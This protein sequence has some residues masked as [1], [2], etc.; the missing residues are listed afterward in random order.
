M[1]QARGRR[2]PADRHCADAGCL[3][4]RFEDDSTS[5]RLL[6][7]YCLERPTGPGLRTVAAIN[8]VR[9]QRLR[10]AQR[11]GTLPT[12]FVPAGLLSL[13]HSNATSWST[14]NPEF[15][16]SKPLTRKERRR[17]VVEAVRRIA[18]SS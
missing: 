7:W 14:M 1:L 16:S 5:L 6:T 13:I 3:F 15:T 10:D 8:D 11:D 2:F 17:T 12:D 9:L 18:S 4:D